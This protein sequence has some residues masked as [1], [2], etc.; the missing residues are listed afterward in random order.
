MKIVRTKDR[1]TTDNNTTF[2]QN[3]IS[4]TLVFDRRKTLGRGSAEEE[5]MACDAQYPCHKML[6][7]HSGSVG[8]TA[9]L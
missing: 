7:R 3:E 1:N 9:R 6:L 5:K 8:S 4:V 2:Q